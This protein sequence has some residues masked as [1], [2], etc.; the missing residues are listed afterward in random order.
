MKKVLLVFI[1][2]LIAGCSTVHPY[3]LCFP[4]TVGEQEING[5]WCRTTKSE[6][7]TPPNKFNRQPDKE[8][9]PFTKSN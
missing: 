1:F 2:F 8:G 5:M 3:L 9:K 7:E 4:V 6:V